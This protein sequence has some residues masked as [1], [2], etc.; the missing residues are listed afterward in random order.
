MKHARR[1]WSLETATDLIPGGIVLTPHGRIGA[2]TAPAFAA[3]LAAAH[4]ES[5]CVVIDLQGVDYISGAGVEALRDVAAREGS[6]AI[7][8]GL[9]EPVRITLELAG[10]LE[11]VVVETTR[12]RAVERVRAS[13]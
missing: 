6:T 11:A 5:A 7:L 12:A 2:A 13:R 8:C 10:L 4:A 9:R 3:A 1:T